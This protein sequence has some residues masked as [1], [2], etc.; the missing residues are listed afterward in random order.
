MSSD[1]NAKSV[2]VKVSL[3]GMVAKGYHA[4]TAVILLC[5]AYTCPKEGRVAHMYPVKKAQ[6]K[7]AFIVHGLLHIIETLYG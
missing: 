4:C 3:V 6:G 2:A 7:D 5:Q 1:N